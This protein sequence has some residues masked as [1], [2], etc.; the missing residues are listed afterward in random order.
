MF[1]PVNVPQ[2][3]HESYKCDGIPD[4]DDSSDEQGCPSRSP[5]DCSDQQFKCKTSGVCVPQVGWEDFWFVYSSHGIPICP[6]K[7]L[8]YNQP[9]VFWKLGASCLM[10]H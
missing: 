4:C 3:I 7:Q 5:N 9:P 8:S 2:C 6:W 1:L 10:G